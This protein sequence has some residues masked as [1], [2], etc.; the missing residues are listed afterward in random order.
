MCG[1]SYRFA[2]QRVVRASW[3]EVCPA[4]TSVRRKKK[5]PIITSSEG[6]IPIRLLWDLRPKSE[7]VF[8][9]QGRANPLPRTRPQNCAPCSFGPV[10][11]NG[12]AARP[13]PLRNASSPVISNSSAAHS[14]RSNLC[15]TEAGARKI[16]NTSVINAVLVDTA[17][18]R[19][20]APNR[21]LRDQTGILVAASRTPV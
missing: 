13:E 8:T 6:T 14:R 12:R 7:N 11:T 17:E 10:P 9:N 20:M 19:K 1:T 2:F 5:P 21:R 18:E 3:L 4:L 15:S 16:C